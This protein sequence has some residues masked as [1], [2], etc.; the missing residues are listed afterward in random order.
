MV[1]LLSVLDFPVFH[2]A[3]DIARAQYRPSRPRKRQEGTRRH[4][5]S[6]PLRG[7]CQY[8]PSSTSWAH[9]LQGVPYTEEM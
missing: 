2:D 3:D 7:Y 6:P 4:S 9:A 5:G 8:Q 1:T